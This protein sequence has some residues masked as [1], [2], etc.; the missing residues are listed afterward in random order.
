MK[1][2]YYVIPETGVT[3]AAQEHPQ[4]LVP[5]VDQL[6]H[7]I[8]L[9][10]ERSTTADH[11]TLHNNTCLKARATLGPDDKFDE[12]IGKSI[13]RDRLIIKETERNIAK[14]AVLQE[15]VRKLQSD[16]DH[17]YEENTKRMNSAYDRLSALEDS[18]VI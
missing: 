15:Q 13:A 8:A 18:G 17:A 6:L 5:G 7:F 11:R 16:I 10:D 2:K 4:E 14:L 12:N 3:I 9:Y 1:Y